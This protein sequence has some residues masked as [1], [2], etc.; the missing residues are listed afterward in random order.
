[1][2]LRRRSAV[3]DRVLW[4]FYSNLIRIREKLLV[5]RACYREKDT[6]IR[7]R[8]VRG[9]LISCLRGT[10]GRRLGINIGISKLEL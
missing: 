9:A 4:I 2:D 10:W 8:I 1:M 3:S 7:S 6:A 5:T